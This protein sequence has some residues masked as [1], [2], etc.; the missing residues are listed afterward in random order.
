MEKNKN[1]SMQLRG[2]IKEVVHVTLED[3]TE[4]NFMPSLHV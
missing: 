3:E 4:D 1:D 2:C